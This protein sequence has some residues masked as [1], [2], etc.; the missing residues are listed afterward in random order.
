MTG[1]LSR[2]VECDRAHEAKAI[3]G[4]NVG[5]LLVGLPEAFAETLVLQI[6]DAGQTSVVAP[7]AAA[8]DRELRPSMANR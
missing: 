6:H 4:K 3:R 8:L 5:A 2:K 7:D 1:S